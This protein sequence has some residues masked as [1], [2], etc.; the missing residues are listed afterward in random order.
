MPANPAIPCWH[1]CQ[2]VVDIIIESNLEMGYLTD[3]ERELQEQLRQLNYIFL[4]RKN[5]LPRKRGSLKISNTS[6]SPPP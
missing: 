6:N 1:F 4:N 3:D 5:K 2:Y